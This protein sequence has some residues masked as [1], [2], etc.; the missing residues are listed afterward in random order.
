MSITSNTT[1]GFFDVSGFDDSEKYGSPKTTVDTSE[2]KSGYTYRDP[3]TLNPRFRLKKA[4]EEIDR[5]RAEVAE[6]KIK[7]GENVYCD[8]SGTS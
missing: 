3:D 7:L 4:L 1:E 5:L 6:L 2:Y 8:D